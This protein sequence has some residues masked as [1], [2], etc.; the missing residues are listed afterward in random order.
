MSPVKLIVFACL[1]AVVRIAAGAEI[2]VSA[3]VADPVVGMIDGEPVTA[4]EYRVVMSRRIA[5]VYAF[6]KE[7]HD[8]DDHPGFWSE[9]ATAPAPLAH[10]RTL[11]REELTRIKVQQVLAK[12]KGLVVDVSFAGFQRDF[13]RE[14]A[15]RRSARDGGELVYGP[16][17]Y[18]EADFYYVRFK[19][20]A[21]QLKRTLAR[22]AAPTIGDADIVAYYETRRDM[23][24]GKPWTEF[25]ESIAKALQER[26]AEQVVAAAVAAAEVEFNELALRTLVPRVDGDE[27]GSASRE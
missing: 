20:L 3:P 12:R 8:R 16:R 21:Y 17:R 22:E 14:N 1:L 11:V 18:G 10:L 2:P 19:E 26:A 27:T 4:A 9:H 23:F 15:R 5:A 7:H 24:G 25:R 6:F 13:E